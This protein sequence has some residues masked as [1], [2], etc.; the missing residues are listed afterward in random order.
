[1]NDHLPHPGW[2]PPAI[3]GWAAFQRIW[4]DASH[5]TDVAGFTEA[6]ARNLKTR[7]GIKPAD[8][9]KRDL[10]MSLAYAVRDL[11]VDR[12][13]EAER[14]SG[15]AGRKRVAYLSMEFLIGRL[16]IANLINLGL[17]G[18]AEKALEPLGATLL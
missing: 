13:H 4:E 6:I 5:G 9:T 7:L 2:A 12:L 15:A 18:V 10:Y 3:G 14:S 11:T 8:A 17:A 1:V 16:L